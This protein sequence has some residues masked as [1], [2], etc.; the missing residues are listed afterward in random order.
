[1]KTYKTWL[2]L[3]VVWLCAG[4][5]YGQTI[6]YENVDNH[7]TIFYPQYV[8]TQQGSFEWKYQF[9]IYGFTF[10]IKDATG[11]ANGGS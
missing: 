6:V 2:A 8:Y 9:P 7:N 5:A 3:C 11:S 10:G 4:M 1:M